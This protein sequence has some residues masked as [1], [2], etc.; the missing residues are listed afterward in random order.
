MPPAFLANITESHAFLLVSLTIELAV[1]LVGVSLCRFTYLRRVRRPGRELTMEDAWVFW[2][3]GKLSDED[4]EL[5][6]LVQRS[7]ADDAVQSIRKELLEIEEQAKKAESPLTPLRAAIMEAVDTSLLN[8]EILDLEDE[9]RRSVQAKL[10]DLYTDEI[11]LWQYLAKDLVCRVLRWYSRRKY[12]DGA[13]GTD[14]FASY[15]KAARTRSRTLVER[16]QHWDAGRGGTGR[17]DLL[18]ANLPGDQSLNELR[19]ELLG[20]R[21]GQPTTPKE[22][23]KDDPRWSW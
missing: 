6:D 18:L 4:R 15:V 20:E 23:A 22:T 17:T 19:A 5:V 3:E 12:G 10:G 11:F 21:Q 7:F 9:A 16:L 1:I 2:M 13:K 14:W 8:K